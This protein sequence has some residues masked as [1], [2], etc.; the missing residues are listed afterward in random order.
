LTFI[1]NLYFEA[2]V[3]FFFFQTLI[4]LNDIT[5]SLLHSRDITSHL[6]GVSALEGWYSGKGQGLT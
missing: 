2:V 5:S 3:L 1:I 6:S 4:I